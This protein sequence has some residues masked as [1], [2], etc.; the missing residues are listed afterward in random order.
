MIA[1]SPPRPQAPR[2]SSPWAE[3]WAARELLRN[4]VLRNLRVKYQRSMLGFVWTLLNPLFTVAVLIGV[5]RFVIRLQ[6]PHY[7]A[8]LFSGYF[9]WNFAAQ[10]LAAATGVLPE[11]SHLSRSVPFP[12]EVLVFSV[13]LSR[14]A[15]YLIEMTLV[16]ALLLG[17]HHRGVPWSLAWLP[18]LLLVQIALVTGLTLPI[19]T[20]SVFFQDVRHALPIALMVLFYASPVFYPASLVPAAVRPLYLLN[21][22]AGLLT[23]YQDVLYHGR[24]PDPA[25]LA[26][27]TTIALALAGIGYAIFRRYRSVFPEIV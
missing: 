26:G 10:T 12:A 15:E 22:F 24:P 4:L 18:V 16:L 13:V 25:V 17:F 7:W 27:T 11:H 3:V 23:M 20:L 9:V 2:P 5:F 1:L 6:V 8:F 19:A 21:P 14:L